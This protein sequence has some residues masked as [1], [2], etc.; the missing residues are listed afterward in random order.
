MLKCEKSFVAT[1]APVVL[2]QTQGKN[3]D[4]CSMR[5]G[6][7]CDVTAESALERLADFSI[8]IMADNLYTYIHNS[9]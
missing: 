1:L 3:K 5:L 9:F 2:D 8:F 6:T 7:R 4:I